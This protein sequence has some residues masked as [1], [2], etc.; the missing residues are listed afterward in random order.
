MQPWLGAHS[1]LKKYFQ[2][3]AIEHVDMEEEAEE[4]VVEQVQLGKK[5]ASDPDE[6]DEVNC[7]RFIKELM[8]TYVVVTS[9][10][11]RKC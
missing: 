11:E 8:E 4:D 7:W 3:D 5:A 1:K 2:D 9:H 6:G 10:E